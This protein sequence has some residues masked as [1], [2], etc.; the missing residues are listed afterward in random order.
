MASCLGAIVGLGVYRRILRF[1]A[2]GFYCRGLGL[3]LEG[4]TSS[5]SMEITRVTISHRGYKHRLSIRLLTSRSSRVCIRIQGC[6]VNRLRDEG[7]FREEKA[8][9]GFEG[10]GCR[11]LGLGEG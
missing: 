7:G 2:S 3:Y 9:G 8:E 10:S 4:L 5:L 6:R 11:G 1:Q